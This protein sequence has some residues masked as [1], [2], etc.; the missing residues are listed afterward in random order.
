MSSSTVHKSESHHHH[1][2]QPFELDQVVEHFNDCA[3][4]DLDLESYLEGYEE[5]LK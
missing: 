2:Q 5:I 4:E 3:N 1:D